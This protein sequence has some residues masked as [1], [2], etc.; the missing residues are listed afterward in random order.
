MDNYGIISQL[1]NELVLE[2]FYL[3]KDEFKQK[4]LSLKDFIKEKVHNEKY[5]D[6]KSYKVLYGRDSTNLCGFYSLFYTINYLKYLF[7]ER[8]VYYL[9]KNTSSKYFYKFYK[10]FL[11]F[12]IENMSSL[13]EYEKIELNKEGSLERHHLDFI[14]KNNI[15]FKYMNT[16]Y[17]SLSSLYKFKFEWF[18]FISNNFSISDIFNIKRLNDIFQEISQKSSAAAPDDSQRIV[19]F[20]YI[21]LTEH[22]ILV[23]YDSFYKNNFLLFDSYRETDDIFNLKYLDKDEINA[24][25]DR[26]NKKIEK[27]KRE[28]LNEYS[29]MQFI[30][31]I[32][33]NQ[34]ILY[35]LNNLIVK[36]DKTFSLG[37]SIVE[38][39]C[40]SFM[41]SFGSLKFNENDKLNKLLVIYYW[42]ANE[43]HPKR[44]KEDFL[45]IMVELGINSKNCDNE[46]IKKFFE[47]A[48]DLSNFFSEN[49]KNIE[50][51][52][53]KEMLEKGFNVFN[54][55][56][57]FN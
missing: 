36:S 10:K 16:K 31:H 57:K 39:R 37:T 41:E 55:I 5:P 49:L 12:F 50:Q 7:N 20:F 27:F 38:E 40:N 3:K 14:L 18:D 6:I 4:S 17:S 45:D 22:W 30:N 13:E 25:I 52:D 32:K 19:Y 44:I 56:N 54:D 46:K 48:N 15:L 47:L 11:P 21:G 9:Y 34:R 43:Y 23:I 33:D 24:F 1:L 53:I 42:F 51:E 26:I 35:K 8:D 28:P 29:T 2:G